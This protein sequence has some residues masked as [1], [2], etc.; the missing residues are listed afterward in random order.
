L[1]RGKERVL[2]EGLDGL[3]EVVYEVITENGCEV[4]RE[5][6]DE[7]VIRPAKTQV[8]RIGTRR[9]SLAKNRLVAEDVIWMEATAYDPGPESNGRFTG[10]PTAYGLKVGF[11]VVAVDPKVIPLG[12]EL[13]IEGYGYA[14]AG[15]TGGAIKNM[16]IDLGYDTRREALRFGRR[17]V[18]VYILNGDYTI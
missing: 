5:A 11:G 16:R 1:A 4:A 7:R 6:V 9:E 8:S 14:I 17:E 10:M 12:T 15:D 2:R 18:K 3:K 13:F